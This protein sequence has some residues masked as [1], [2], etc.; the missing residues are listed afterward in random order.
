MQVSEYCTI[1]SALTGAHWA[2]LLVRIKQSC[3]VHRDG[4]SKMF[5]KTTL[6]CLWTA[7]ISAWL[8]SDVRTPCLFWKMRIAMEAWNLTRRASP[9][10]TACRSA[11]VMR[12]TSST[13]PLFPTRTVCLFSKSRP[14]SKRGE[15]ALTLYKRQVIHRSFDGTILLFVW[16]FFLGSQACCVW[17][18]LWC[19]AA[20]RPLTTWPYAMSKLSRTT[21]WIPTVLARVGIVQTYK[22]HESRPT[23]FIV[24][25]VEGKQRVTV[26]WKWTNAY[27]S[28]IASTFLAL[29]RTVWA[30]SW[31]APQPTVTHGNKTNHKKAIHIS[32]TGILQQRHPAKLPHPQLTSCSMSDTWVRCQSNAGAMVAMRSSGFKA[33]KPAKQ[34]K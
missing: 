28:T 21:T 31:S 3:S 25:C 26:A 12:L 16:L 20:T 22:V 8:P 7:I 29:T 14:R 24:P 17:C 6:N 9:S 27:E 33:Y 19:A 13:L 11:L 30:S 32:H 15:G 4:S 18:T 34:D 10:L 1:D 2:E 5:G 23:D